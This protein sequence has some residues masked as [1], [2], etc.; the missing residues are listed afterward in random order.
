MPCTDYGR[1]AYEAKQNRKVDLQ[2]IDD[3]TAMLCSASKTLEDFN[4]DFDKNPLLSKWWDNHKKLDIKAA[5]QQTTKRLLYEEAVVISKKP[6]NQ[7]TD[8]DKT[9]LKRE[10]FL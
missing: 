3:L 5:Q 8:S 9:I 2:E 6:F 10:G 1:D 4:Y 7:L